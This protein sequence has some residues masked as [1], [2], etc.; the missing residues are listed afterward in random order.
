MVTS[1]FDSPLGV[2]LPGWRDSPSASRRRN[3]TTVVRPRGWRR[4]GDS[5]RLRLMVTDGR[6]VCWCATTTPWSARGDEAVGRRGRHRGRGAA[7][8]GEEGVELAHALGPDIVLMDLAMPGIDG[9][10]A[11]RRISSALAGT[12]IVILTSFGDDGRVRDAIGAGAVGFVL[13][14]TDGH[15]LVRA[16][17]AAARGEVPLDPRAAGALLTRSRRP[18]DLA[19]MTA[20]EREVLAAPQRRA[21][22]Q[23]D[24]P[25]AGHQPGHRQG[26]PDSDLPPRRRRRP[27]A[28][29]AA[30][31][32]STSRP[33][34]R[35]RATDA[36]RCT[37]NV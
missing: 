17:L 11:T 32:A 8:S 19:G 22:Q 15:D 35:G 12:R 9:V 30:G 20:R 18:A 36:L 7:A 4:R 33:T 10:E 16:V 23:G 37:T 5:F 28:G 27:H 1:R 13:K 26:A 6:S 2:P 21:G 25:A 3:A 14:D 31:R 34:A 24:R 29:R